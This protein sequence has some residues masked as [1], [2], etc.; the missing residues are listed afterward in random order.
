MANLA[1]AS[2]LEESVD[3][4]KTGFLDVSHI[5]QVF[6]SLGVPEADIAALLKASGS[7]RDAGIDYVD[8]LEWLFLPSEPPRAAENS[9]IPLG[10][11]Q[12]LVSERRDW[13]QTRSWNSHVKAEQR[14]TM[15]EVVPHIIKP[16]TKSRRCSYAELLEAMAPQVFVSH[17]WGE[18]FVN[19]VQALYCYA[20]AQHPLQRN[21]R[22]GL[23][24]WICS[25]ANRQWTVDLG[26]SLEESPFER[27]LGASSCDTV[28]MVVDKSVS[29]LQRIW[30]LYE[31][32]RAHALEKTFHVATEHGVLTYGQE[33]P[34]DEVRADL[35]KLSEK[36]MLLDASSAQ[37]SQDSDR[38]A[39]LQ[40][41]E[42]QVGLEQFTVHVK[43]LLAKS[44]ARRGGSAMGVEHQDLAMKL[45]KIQWQHNAMVSFSG[46]TA[47]HVAAQRGSLE[48]VQRC[49]QEE[50]ADINSRTGLGQTPL[51][52]AAG[53]AEASSGVLSAL[54]EGSADAAAVD[55]TE[56][57][58]TPFAFAAFNGQI[59]SLEVLYRAVGDQVL[60]AGALRSI[61]G[62]EIPT[63]PM[64]FAAL[65]GHTSCVQFM[66]DRGTQVDAASFS[67][68]AMSSEQVPVLKVLLKARADPD[69][70]LEGGPPPALGIASIL[71]H[72][73]CIEA[74]LEH[75]ADVNRRV[76]AGGQQSFPFV[77]AIGAGHAAAAALLLEH[78]ADPWVKIE[79]S[80]DSALMIACGG[81]HMQCIQQMLSLQADVNERNEVEGYSPIHNAANWGRDTVIQLLVQQRADVLARD[82]KQQTPLHKAAMF[83]YCET[84]RTLLE[85]GARLE[86]KDDQGRT[87]ADL[88]WDEDEPEA[89]KLLDSMML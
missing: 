79:P 30:C 41:I 51:H 23:V 29:P 31:V 24:Y 15:Y 11:L 80:G 74:L 52:L 86:E 65:N 46:R 45:R 47:L 39:I 34:H 33:E 76:S 18:E 59:N 61:N 36:V 72:I 3:T 25:F 67:L 2:K 57:M 78:S 28:L 17:W 54:L 82:F 48:Q 55:Q 66:L 19:F 60:Q 35:L 27:A 32:L 10:E 77:V 13:L 42:E 8:L 69:Q 87:A 84:L 88:A 43:S 64:I 63:S 20:L 16:R 21:L 58:L 89:A 56:F 5:V 62:I 85:L 26:G 53:F 49:L 73:D 38:R 83:G 68:L 6:T 40:A 44:F 71:G 1:L 81:G 22:D 9:G 75:S 12:R 70:Q 14:P 4:E 37:A 7:K 50:H